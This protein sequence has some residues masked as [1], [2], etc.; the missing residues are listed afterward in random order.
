[1]KGAIRHMMISPEGF[2]QEYIDKPY[3]ELLCVRDDLAAKIRDF[4][5]CEINPTE[6]IMSPSPEVIYQC[7][8][9]YLGKLC[10]L[11]S[12]KYNREFVSCED[13]DNENYLF[14]IRDFLDSRGLR[15]ESTLNDQIEERKKGKKYSI[16][17]HIRALIYAMLTNQ[18]KW[19]RIESHLMEIDELFLNYD[20]VI[21]KST[22]GEYFANKL[23]ELK[24]GNIS[25]ISQMN[26]LSYNINILESIEKEYGS[27]DLF[28]LSSP[29]H[30]MVQ[31]LSK[32]NSKYKLKM[33]GEALA[34]EYLR[35]VGI[36]GAKPDVHLCRFFSGSRM[37][38][39]NHTPATTREVYNSVLELSKATGLSMTTIDNY[40]WSYCADG[41]G[42]VCTSVPRC[43]ICEI[44]QQCN[45]TK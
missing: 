1:M 28:V 29:A 37:G 3:A 12:E 34:W 19:H 44:R 14:K 21:L 6:I 30:E 33:L 5:K 43:S 40:I 18:T 24:C 9:K 36:D 4:E 22:A 13:K 7:N 2:I 20:P 8:L 15:Y 38:N 31:V 35:N 11:I 41:Y 42:E 25:T 10:E 16:C 27:L 32:K 23:F 39:G 17:E 45:Y 26:A